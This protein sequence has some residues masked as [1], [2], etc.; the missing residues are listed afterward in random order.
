MSGNPAA[1]ALRIVGRDLDLRG[2]KTFIIRCDRNGF[3]VNGGY[4]PPP[5]V[6]PV[7]VHYASAI[8]IASSSTQRTTIAYQQQ[9]IFRVLRKFY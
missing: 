3:V 5:S 2:I 8:S 4:Q 1:E 7:T 9:E 6:M